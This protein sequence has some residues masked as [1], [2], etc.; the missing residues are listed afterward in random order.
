MYCKI[1]VIMN[2]SVKHKMFQF[3]DLQ[4]YLLETKCKHNKQFKFN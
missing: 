4:M 1:Y 3:T 2:S